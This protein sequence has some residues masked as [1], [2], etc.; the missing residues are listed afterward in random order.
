MGD[1][2]LYISELNKESEFE[3]KNGKITFHILESEYSNRANFQEK[4]TISNTELINK[5]CTMLQ[6]EMQQ[7]VKTLETE[8]LTA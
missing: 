7:K 3:T 6:N 4:F 1:L 5:F 8:L 2:Q